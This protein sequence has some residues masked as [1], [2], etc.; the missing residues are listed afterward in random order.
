MLRLTLACPSAL[1]DNF[2]FAV[3]S[4]HKALLLV[5]EA[6]CWGDAVQL[7]DAALP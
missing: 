5:F 3:F 6:S 2:T 7:R 4:N 1:I